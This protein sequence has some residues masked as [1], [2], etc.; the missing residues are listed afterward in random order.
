M[1]ENFN[2]KKA[3]LDIRNDFTKGHILKALWKYFLIILGSI[4]LAAGDEFFLIPY[5]IVSGGVAGIGVVLN[6]SLGWD[7]NVVITV[8]QWALFVLG[9][10]L[11]GARFTLK[12]LLSSAV[13]TGFLFIFSQVRNNTTFFNIEN[14]F[15]NEPLATFLVCGI[16]GGA[17]VGIGCGCTFI[18]GGSTG[19]TD[20]FSLSLTKYFYISASVT[21]F[22]IDA[23]II[24]LNTAFVPNIAPVIIGSISAY[25][26]ATL[27]GKLYISNDSYVAIII[28]SEW[29]AISDAIN[30]SLERG[31]TL[32]ECEGGYTGETRTMVLSVFSRREY[33]DIQK[34]VFREDP[35]AFVT[36]LQGSEVN[37]EGFRKIPYRINRE[38]RYEN[39][40]IHKKK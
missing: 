8:F 27:I 12:T 25:A 28:S 15:P 18:G 24:L 22:A 2:L 4:V 38:I 13:Y 6:M 16:A 34:I 26:C 7:A 31:T 19:G 10:V 30:T 37:G 20:V 29:Q 21:S 39:R 33:D 32:A 9:F 36:I 3:F 23:I 17:M 40:F 35:K 11:L 5:N 1:K 14:L